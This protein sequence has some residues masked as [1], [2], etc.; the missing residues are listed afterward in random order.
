MEFIR[1]IRRS[2]HLNSLSK[3]PLQRVSLNVLRNIRV[4]V[5]GENRVVCHHVVNVQLDL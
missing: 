3:G 5:L 1:I 4:E 2:V